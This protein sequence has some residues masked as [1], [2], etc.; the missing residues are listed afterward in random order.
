MA[1]NS[2]LRKA[3][4]AIA[5]TGV[6]LAVSTAPANAQT[7]STIGCSFGSNADYAVLCSQ[8]LTGQLGDKIITLLGGQTSTGASSGTFEFEWTD[9]AGGFENDLFETRATFDPS[10]ANASGAFGYIIEIAPEQIAEGYQFATVALD[11][12]GSFG[13][14]G[15]TVTK[16]SG[17]IGG[18]P[19]AFIPDGV[20]SL[21][22]INGNPD[23][24]PTPPGFAVSGTK[25]TIVD[26]FTISG[27]ATLQAISNVW[28]QQKTDVPGPLPLLGA[29]AAFGFSRRMRS[30][31]KFAS[32]TA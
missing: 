27:T 13:A 6:G 26:A 4:I 21:T 19:L 16:R 3:A 7:S 32:R 31:I 18:D 8:G 30:R 2:F 5:T 17:S 20:I 10:I 25:F 1:S 24:N 12:D 9:F 15:A 14:G 28:T 23:P 22:S 29:A 11:A